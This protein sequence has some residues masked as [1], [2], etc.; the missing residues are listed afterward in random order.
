VSRYKSRRSN[1]NTKILTTIFSILI[2]LSV[3][4]S[5]AGSFFLSGS[6][7]PPP[8]PTFTPVVTSRPTSSPVPTAGVP[9]PV[10]VTPTSNP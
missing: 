6:G 8:P 9:T 3:I 10:L 1:R 5:L 4:F 7:N 2:V